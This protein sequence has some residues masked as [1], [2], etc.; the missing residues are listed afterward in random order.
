MDWVT[1]ICVSA[2]VRCLE[3]TIDFPAI[4]SLVGGF[5]LSRAFLKN[6]RL[7]SF[8]KS[9][10]K[11]KYYSQD[12]IFYWHQ[13]KTVL[14][15]VVA[16]TG[17][18]IALG[19][20]V[21]C[22]SKIIPR[23]LIFSLHSISI[24]RTE[25]F[26]TEVV[27]LS[28]LNCGLRTPRCCHCCPIIHVVGIKYLVVDWFGNA[29]DLDWGFCFVSYSMESSAFKVQSDGLQDSWLKATPIFNNRP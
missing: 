2:V 23:Y 26:G 12:A 6:P 4:A 21:L 16:Q 28:E 13:G 11:A 17:H 22:L 10:P 27:C 24:R 18:R 7:K 14:K 8:R 29:C 19:R 20:C 15:A 25:P 1:L 3:S 5:L 9:S